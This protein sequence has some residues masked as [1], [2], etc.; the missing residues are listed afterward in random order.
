MICCDYMFIM[1]LMW[2]T[3]IC[4][5]SLI[6]A[7]RNSKHEPMDVASLF[8]LVPYLKMPS[9]LSVN[10]HI[11]F[12][13]LH[14]Q[15]SFIPFHKRWIVALLPVIHPTTM[16]TT[17]M[18]TTATTTNNPSTRFWNARQMHRE[19]ICRCWVRN[20]QTTEHKLTWITI[21][22]LYSR[23]KPRA[24]KSIFNEK[25]AKSREDGFNFYTYL[26]HP[27]ICFQI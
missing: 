10:F 23:K 18:T 3:S 1:C 6:R 21:L 16:T 22:P 24:V 11:L 2:S 7:K 17:T 13:I 5:S 20:R 25:S 19:T 9:F 27:I 26:S 14:L 15:S 4:Q 12:S 8:F